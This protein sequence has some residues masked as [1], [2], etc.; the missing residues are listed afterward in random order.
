MASYNSPNEVEEHVEPTLFHLDMEISQ[1]RINQLVKDRCGAKEICPEL[2]HHEFI[3]EPSVYK[4]FLDLDEK[5]RFRRTMLQTLKG[6]WVERHGT[7]EAVRVI[8]IF[9]NLAHKLDEN[10]AL[11]FASV[12]E[13]EKFQ[14][15]IDK[16]RSTL[17]ASGSKS[18]IHTFVNLGNH[19]EFLTDEEFNDSFLHPL[20]LALV[21]YRVGG[22]IR[23]VDARGKDA[24]PISVLAQDNMLHIDNTP[25]CDEYKVILT[26]EK[27]KPSG[28]KG[29]NMVF[30]PGTQ[31]GS[32]NC[33]TGD[34][35]G[36]WSTENASIFV[37]EAAIERLFHFQKD[38]RQA[39]NPIVVEVTHDEKPL[40]TVFAAG[41][42]V[43]HRYRTAEGCSR[44]CVII[45]FHQVSDNPGHLIALEHLEGLLNQRP[46]TKFIFGHHSG[47][48]N[49]DFVAALSQKS[50]R[51]WSLL[52][53]LESDDAVQEVIPLETLKLSNAKV[54]KWRNST[55]EAPTV[56]ELKIESHITQARRNLEKKEF[57]RLVH[58]MM[59]FD[60]HGPIDLILYSDGHEEIRKWARNQIREMNIDEM[61]DRLESEWGKH[62]KQP[63][64]Q[65]ILT[66]KELEN[67]TKSLLKIAQTQKCSNNII[68]F[69]EKISSDRAYD[70][71][72]QLFVD[73][74]ESVIRCENR[75]A[76]LSTSL[77]IFLAADMLL[78]FQE[79]GDC[80]IQCIGQKLLN[81]YVSMAVLINKQI[82][83]EILLK[84]SNPNE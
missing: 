49:T 65:S 75:Q 42:L 64:E 36:V 78:K 35:H 63:S 34:E 53:G 54:G 47:D 19:P 48:M 71:I 79:P 82:G 80:N 12:I 69:Q 26:W 21:S 62:L 60:K 74:G 68:N 27:D 29:Q 9:E 37:S 25:F 33:F 32:R 38:V 77:F 81:H 55:T 15:L 6:L 39:E 52:L 14:K 72:I 2:V 67:S 24:E 40:T 57:V 11:V 41:S 31:K 66:A 23:I 84:H 76:F 46:L 18:W 10:G 16:Y 73:L 17:D 61:K 22:A 50:E 4:R 3:Q 8:G 43:H 1:D 28:P 7:E 20:L 59:S 44:S 83:L 70:S 45:A 30:L 56:E 13:V 58:E 51:I 5:D